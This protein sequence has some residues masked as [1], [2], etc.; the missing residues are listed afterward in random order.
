MPAAHDFGRI[1]HGAPRD[2]ER[3]TREQCSEVNA[4]I[5]AGAKQAAANAQR[6]DDA[7]EQ[8]HNAEGT[9]DQN[10]R[11]VLHRGEPRKHADV[12][13]GVV[14]EFRGIGDAEVRWGC[15]H[16]DV[17]PPVARP[18]GQQRTEQDAEQDGGG[19]E[20][21]AR[22]GFDDLQVAEPARHLHG[23]DGPID[24]QQI[25]GQPRRRHD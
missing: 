18:Q 8:R 4:R 21:A 2:D 22:D 11:A 24:D 3:E 12:V 14:T 5:V 9:H 25:A 10:Q 7:V 23:A 16:D 15:R 17:T 13:A 1:E 20:R 6:A 19:K